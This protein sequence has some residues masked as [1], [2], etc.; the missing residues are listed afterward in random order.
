[1]SATFTAIVEGKEA[2]EIDNN[3]MLSTVPI[4][5]HGDSKFL[6]TFP[7]R[8]RDGRPQTH[9]E[10]RKQVSRFAGGW[11]RR[12]FAAEAGRRRVVGGEPPEPPLRPARER[13]EHM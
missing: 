9:D 3:F 11:R 1:V 6:S 12:S 5:M 8:N 13:S 7:K 4:K 10:M 2:K